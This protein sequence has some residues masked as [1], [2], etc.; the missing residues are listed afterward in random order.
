MS[1]TDALVGI[2]FKQDDRGRTLFF[3]NGVLGRGYVVPD[4]AGEARLRRVMTWLQF[5]AI[6]GGVGALLVAQI[7]VGPLVEWPPGMWLGFSAAVVGLMVLIRL[8]VM[9]LV[10]GLAPAPQD[11][12]LKLR[13]V[14]AQQAL[15]LPRWYH[16]L[17]VAFSGLL[18]V[19]SLILLIF[20]EQM[21]M[22]ALVG[23]VMFGAITAYSIYGLNAGA[24]R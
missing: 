13:E 1:L 21:T 17:Q 7:V 22:T 24:K 10:R 3:P 18:C 6:L 23:V 11:A 12:R 16:W 5:G 19:T 9:R 2:L 8:A 14:Y 20:D 15:A 4:A